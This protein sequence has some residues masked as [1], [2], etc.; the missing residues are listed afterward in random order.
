MIRWFRDS[1]SRLFY[2]RRV[3]LKFKYKCGKVRVM[4]DGKRD[5]F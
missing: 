1:E 4:L 3:S 2:M 5:A